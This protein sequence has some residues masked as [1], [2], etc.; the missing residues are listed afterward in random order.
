[1][2]MYTLAFD[3]IQ[4]LLTAFLG[5]AFNKRLN[6]IQQDDERN[7][8]AYKWTH[9]KQ[10]NSEEQILKSYA[11]ALYQIKE[12]CR[13][14]YR[15]KSYEEKATAWRAAVD[16]QRIL[17]KIQMETAAYTE[18]NIATKCLEL[19]IQ[20]LKC[21]YYVSNGIDIEDGQTKYE[22]MPFVEK[23]KIRTGLKVATDRCDILYGELAYLVK[24]FKNEY[25]PKD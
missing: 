9:D 13:K 17:Y 3:V 15:N 10:R 16:H 6:K 23:G 22:K 25:K 18:A 21:L 19:Y 24:E 4:I 1:M 11:D 5:F 2:D 7:L 8:H 14:V 20:F 12:C